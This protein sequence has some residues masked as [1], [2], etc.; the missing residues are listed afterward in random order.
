M[1]EIFKLVLSLSLSGSVLAVLVYLCCLLLR[2]RLTKR[3]QYYIWLVV[4]LRLLLPFSPESAIL[5]RL[6]EPAPPV[7]AVAPDNP[8]EAPDV[9]I[10][11]PP[12]IA[13]SEAETPPVT[14]Q[15][16]PSAT[17]E[18]QEKNPILPMPR[19][20]WQ[21]LWI[22]WLAVAA[23]LLIRK[24]TLYQ[25]FVKYLRAGRTVV[26]DVETL[27]RF[28]ALSEAM[29]VRRAVDLYT[30]RLT[31]SPLILGFRKPAI[32]LPEV[33]GSAEE[34][35]FICKH[36]LTHYKRGDIWYKWLLQIV[37][38]LHWFN[39]LVH[40]MVREVNRLCELSCD[41]AVLRTLTNQEHRRYGD[42]LLKSLQ[43][44]GTYR[45]GLAALTLNESA[46][47]LKE[48]LESIMKFTRPNKTT[49]MLAIVLSALLFT[50]GYALGAY[51]V[52]PEPL[53]HEQNS[54]LSPEGLP[55]MSAANREIYEAYLQ[56]I[57]VT[58][59]LRAD[60]TPEDP[61]ALIADG[62]GIMQSVFNVINPEALEKQAGAVPSAVVVD[63]LIGKL[64]V[65][66]DVIRDAFSGIYDEATDTFEL[67]GGLGGGP[68]TPIVTGS[69][70]Q[71]ELLTISYTWYDADP[72]ADEF[73]YKAGAEGTLVVRL[74]G[75][76]Y[77]YVSN[78][79]D[80]PESEIIS[81]E[82]AVVLGQAAKKLAEEFSKSVAYDKEEN[83]LSFTVPE[84]SFHGCFYNI[85][86]MARMKMG[87]DSGFVQLFG[88]AVANDWPAG[89]YSHQFEKDSVLD[90]T[91]TISV[92]AGYPPTILS[93]AGIN[94]DG[95]GDVEIEYLASFPR[96][97]TSPES[98]GSEATVN[99]L[100]VKEGITII[101]VPVPLRDF[102][103]NM[104]KSSEV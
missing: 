79:V 48:R 42:T 52:A 103:V 23:G 75:G 66:E 31:A 59:L 55:V 27:D 91:I 101:T 35:R 32:V 10:T 3:F 36:E 9:L 19:Q 24:I 67:Y 30:N 50:G 83:K 2:K 61:S 49:A 69:G 78:K 88:D 84:T 76:D 65:P 86:A 17:R 43:T 80:P 4:V 81:A 87:D 53:A 11:P 37:L 99:A 15:P 93:E 98:A 8:E 63:T 70:I 14:P 6:W 29:G 73:R 45:E 96:E 72:A 97:E 33:P 54:G 44:P 85:S 94:V 28:S 21:Y 90:V 92:M 38:C 104:D 16:Q 100:A 12:V 56:H 5:P 26:D 34:L 89:P 18:A 47:T 46:R 77:Q 68:S 64:P 82:D 60:F 25:S 40:L 1:N 13:S 57:S 22:L 41:E 95:N 74:K 39:P 58:G 62:G 71:G 102:A 20:F 51:Y 7:Q